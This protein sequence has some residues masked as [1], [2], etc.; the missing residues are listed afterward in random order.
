MTE[1][2]DLVENYIQWLK[3]KTVLRKLNSWMEITTPHLDRHNDYI[4][5]YAK[6]DEDGSIILT[7]DS[8]TITDLEFSGCA[9]DTPKRKAMLDVTLNGFGVEK[10]GD[11]LRVRA[12]PENFPLRKHSLIQ[13]ILAVNDL[14]VLSQLSVESFFLEDVTI[15]LDSHDVRY[16]PNAKFQGLSG[17]EHKFDFVIPKSKHSPERLINTINNPK[18]GTAQNAAFSWMDTKDSRPENSQA[19]FLLNDTETKVSPSVNQ[20]LKNYGITPVPWSHRENFT[21]RLAA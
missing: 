10:F 16:V 12:T 2:H 9:L 13:A 20:A 8:Q 15:W 4:Q 18:K 7:D 14:F 11:A 19:F 3:D 21:E 6:K 17:F 5:I 1:I